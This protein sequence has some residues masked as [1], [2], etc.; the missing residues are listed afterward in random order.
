MINTH[1]VGMI[2]HDREDTSQTPLGNPTSS[3]LPFPH[4]LNRRDLIG[5]SLQYNTSINHKVSEVR[6]EVKM[7]PNF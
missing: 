1:T 3:A 4:P 2:Q 5:L 6:T 7:A